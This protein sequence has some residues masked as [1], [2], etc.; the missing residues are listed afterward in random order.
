MLSG[1]LWLLEF[2][3]AALSRWLRLGVSSVYGWARIH[4]PPKTWASSL[5]CSFTSFGSF[6]NTNMPSPPPKFQPC[7]QG[8]RLPFVKILSLTTGNCSFPTLT[9]KARSHRYWNILL[10]IFKEFIYLFLER[11]EEREI[12]REK[13]Q[14]VV[15]SHAPSTGDLAHNPGICPDWESNRWPLVHSPSSIYWATPTRAYFTF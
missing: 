10:F 9:V 12:E 14:C 7:F 1:V 13:H 2:V 5:L 8:H 3:N 15:A 11:R 6:G 4:V